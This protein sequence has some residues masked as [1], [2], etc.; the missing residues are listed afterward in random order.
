MRVHASLDAS[1]CLH[2]CASLSLRAFCLAPR[3]RNF[4]ITH[5]PLR[6][7]AG[8]TDLLK[9]ICSCDGVGLSNTQSLVATEWLKNCTDSTP[10]RL[11]QMVPN[12]T[13]FSADGNSLPLDVACKQNMV[14]NWSRKW[15]RV[16]GKQGLKSVQNVIPCH[17]CLAI[18]CWE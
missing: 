2:A 3:A 12:Q 1:G 9:S 15:E 10:L 7:R 5:A 4:R 16:R 14:R 17:H 11:R 6:K 13:T 8:F 18:F